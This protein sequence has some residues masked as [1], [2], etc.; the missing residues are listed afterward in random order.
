[1][2]FC[3]RCYTLLVVDTA[4]G[5]LLFVCPRCGSNKN[6]EPEDTLVYNEDPNSTKTMDQFNTMIRNAPK[7][8]SR[9]L[10]DYKCKCG[11][12]YVTHMRIGEN[13][14]VLFIC[15]CGEKYSSEEIKKINN[16]AN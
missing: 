5:N 9:Y 13:E 10:F 1:M 2:K 14:K 7:D 15:E 8:P 6:P 16:I 3:R 12:P 4:S 11:M